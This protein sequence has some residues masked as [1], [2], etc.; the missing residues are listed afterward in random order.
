MS[1]LLGER[2]EVGKFRGT[3]IWPNRRRPAIIFSMKYDFSQVSWDDQT[4]AD[5]QALLR[6]AL[7]EDLGA[8]GDCTTLSLV[9]AE[10]EGEAVLAARVWGILAGCYA[11]EQTIAAIHP[12][13]VWI[14]Q[15]SDGDSVEKGSRVGTLRGPVRALLAAERLVLNVLSRLSGIAT[16]TQQYVKAV[17]GTKARIYDTRKTTPGWRRLEK[18][19]VRC[20]GGHNHR[21]GLFDAILIK[22]NHLAWGATASEMHYTPAEAVVRARHFISTHRK[23]VEAHPAI[24]EVEVDTLEQLENVLSVHPDI[25]L[26]DNMPPSMLREAV[27][28]RTRIAPQVELE[29][30][31]G[32]TLDTVRAIAE[33]GVERISSGALTHSAVALDFGLDWKMG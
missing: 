29:A 24:V 10:A 15:L 26:L 19:A 2:S 22:D 11:V 25:V 9:S 32:V 28:L 5:W 4:E 20:G 12:N 6:M 7:Q 8:E 31:G 13:L 21:L 16:L 18:Y 3:A 1:V 30:S 27:A 23:N 33:T 14:A 17:A